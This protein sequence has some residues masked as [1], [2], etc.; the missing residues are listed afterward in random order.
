MPKLTIDFSD[1]ID[2][3]KVK[4]AA[5]LHLLAICR[6][7]LPDGRKEGGEYVALNP[8]RDDKNLGSF[9]INLETGRWADFAED[10]NAKGGDII[11]LI[12]YLYEMEPFEAA[13][14]VAR[15]VGIKK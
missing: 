14:A 6:R 15:M 1:S 12:S 5:A 8:L 7:V 10:D 4:D 2:F 9:R 13:I 11:S 3:Q